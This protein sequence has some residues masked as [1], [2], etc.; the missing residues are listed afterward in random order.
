MLR[1]DKSAGV[2]YGHPGSMVE[3]GLSIYMGA[4]KADGTKASRTGKSRWLDHQKDIHCSPGT[5]V[6]G[7]PAGFLSK[8]Q[9]MSTPCEDM[10]PML[11]AHGLVFDDTLNGRSRQSEAQQQ[12]PVFISGNVL[13]KTVPGNAS[14]LPLKFHLKNG[15]L[16]DTHSRIKNILV[17]F[18]RPFYMDPEEDALWNRTEVTRCPRQGFD[19]QE[20][21]D[22][23]VS[24]G[25]CA[26]GF[27]FVTD[28]G[29][30]EADKRL[31]QMTARYLVDRLVA[32]LS[33]RSEWA[34]RAPVQQQATEAFREELRNASRASPAYGHD[35]AERSLRRML[36]LRLNPC[37]PEGDIDEAMDPEAAARRKQQ[38]RMAFQRAAT[39]KRACFCKKAGFHDACHF[40]IVHLF[41]QLK[42]QAPAAHAYWTRL[43][44]VEFIPAVQNALGLESMTIPPKHNKSIRNGIWGWK[45]VPEGESGTDGT[46]WDVHIE[47]AEGVLVQEDEGEAADVERV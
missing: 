38:Q 33:G 18:N 41:Q 9:E 31:L 1:A 14:H 47:T 23:A 34:P 13:K 7:M 12:K 17:A 22:A 36:Q 6:S 37:A 40:R 32:V 4:N 30:V 27:A 2:L 5:L 43:G 3:A 19:T 10:K 25:E 21:V 16:I 39:G 35:D 42:V 15:A 11:D 20:L 46:P 24:R 45:L 44:M 26:P 8:E 29:R 28:P